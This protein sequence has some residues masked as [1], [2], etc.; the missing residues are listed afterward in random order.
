[1]YSD[2]NNNEKPDPRKR[3]L[4]VLL[5]LSVVAAGYVSCDNSIDPLDENDLYSNYGMLG[6]FRDTNYIRVKKLNSPLLADSTRSLNATVTLKNL[7]TG[8]TQILEDSVVRFD[9]I[10][11]HN[12]LTTLNILADSWYLLTVAKQNE[13]KLTTK[14]KTPNIANLDVQIEYPDVPPPYSPEIPPPP[15]R[16]TLTFKFHPVKELA[17]LRYRH[18]F[19]PDSLYEGKGC[20]RVIQKCSGSCGEG[21]FCVFGRCRSYLPG[22]NFCEVRRIYKNMT[23]YTNTRLLKIKRDFVIKKTVTDTVCG[24]DL[25]WKHYAAGSF[26]AIKYLESDTLSIP[27]GGGF[28]GAYYVRDTLIIFPVNPDL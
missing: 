6:V 7:I 20:Y 28:F 1:M 11:T 2:R 26:N 8:Q 10:Y 5:I 19:K 18:D 15:C 12:F 16:A 13:V 23:T 17:N 21:A 22:D 3:Y 25:T 9:S 14:A 4:R 27:G 24:L